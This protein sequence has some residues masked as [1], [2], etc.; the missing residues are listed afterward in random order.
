ME[1]RESTAPYHYRQQLNQCVVFQI[2]TLPETVR[3][4]RNQPRFVLDVL[5]V[6][7]LALVTSYLS[8]QSATPFY[9]FSVA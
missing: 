2:T 4:Y 6:V 1:A 5:C 9:P 8:S 7:P 3:E